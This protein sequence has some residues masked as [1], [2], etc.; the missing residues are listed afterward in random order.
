MTEQAT[1]ELYV[2]TGWAGYFGE[3]FQRGEAWLDCSNGA[4]QAQTLALALEAAGDVLGQRCID[5]GCGRGQL[6][7]ALA[8]FGAEEVVGVDFVTDTVAELRRRAPGVDWRW[9]DAGEDGT[10]AVIPA[11]D[12]VFL[13]EVLQ[14]LDAP[15]ALRRWWDR[16]RPGGRLVVVV[17]NADCPIVWRTRARLAGYCPL[18]PADVAGVVASLPDVADWTF[19]GLLFRD[20]QALAPYD[21]SGWGREDDRWPE[22]PNRLQFVVHRAA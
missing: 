3:V 10:A 4:V 14:Y 19:R 16:V 5:V 15:V 1:S 7:R 20:D 18:S 11:G 8:A 9:G 2:G 21:V 13:V 22:P 12:V 6:A 17:P